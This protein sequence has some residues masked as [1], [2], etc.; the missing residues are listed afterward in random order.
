[1]ERFLNLTKGDTSIKW[2]ELG[3]ESLHGIGGN[4]TS[5]DVGALTASLDVRAI[6]TSLDVGAI[7]YTGNTPLSG[8]CMVPKQAL[9]I[10]KCEVNRILC[11]SSDGTRIIPV[12]TIVPRKNHLDFHADL[13]PDSACGS[14]SLKFDEWK[15][16]RNVTRNKVCLDP[17]LKKQD[18]FIMDVGFESVIKDS[19]MKVVG[20]ES[21]IDI[22]ETSETEI[23]A[24]L[25]VLKNGINFVGPR[26]SVQKARSYSNASTYLPKHS[27]YRHVVVETNS[28]YSSL[29]SQSF[30][31]S[32][33]SDGFDMN[34][35][36][37]AF[38]QQQGT[39][40][41]VGVWP[42][43]NTGRFPAKAPSIINGT[44][45]NDF[46]FDPFRNDRILTGCED[47]KLRI[48]KVILIYD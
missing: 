10:L 32:P 43:K 16:G 38:F 20:V 37:F 3:H 24:H 1:V 9:N 30:D 6:T 22:I 41:R 13:F 7:P 25:D 18:C 2:L 5:L 31:I 23:P 40:G 11:I 44:E 42:C 12:S 8:F 14:Y 26:S 27:N 48:F 17:F 4:T 35:E 19:F 33:E 36:Y 34:S 29:V 39:G 21:V 46:K 45:V 28:K 47:G 15:T